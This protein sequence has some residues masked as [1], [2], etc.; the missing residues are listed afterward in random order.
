MLAFYI[1]SCSISQENSGSVKNRRRK[2][3]IYPALIREIFSRREPLSSCV[4]MCMYGNFTFRLVTVHAQCSL[5]TNVAPSLE[6]S[7]PL[8]PPPSAR[9]DRLY[10]Q[11]RKKKDLERGKESVHTCC[12]SWEG[13]GKNKTTA[14]DEGFFYSEPVFLNVYGA[15]ESIPRNEFRQPM[16]PDGPPVR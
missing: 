10:L 13:G 3:C 12:G 4:I 2:A 11:H 9:I 8:P 15:Q 6:L 14:K 5:L 16:K 1:F 7:P